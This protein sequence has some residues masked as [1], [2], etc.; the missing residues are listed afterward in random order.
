MTDIVNAIAGATVDP[1]QLYGLPTNGAEDINLAAVT[2]ITDFAD[3]QANHM[4]Q[5]G[6]DVLINT[7]DGTSITLVGVTLG[8]LQAEDFI[9]TM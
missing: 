7:G 9:F 1:T 5:N 2:A 3:L 4:S 8:D 6:S